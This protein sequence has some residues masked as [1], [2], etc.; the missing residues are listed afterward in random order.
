MAIG[1]DPAVPPIEGTEYAIQAVDTYEMAEQLGERTV[2]IGGGTIGCELALLLDSYGKKTTVLE[3][4]D[5]LHRQNS[6]FYDIALDQQ[7]AI[8][9]GIETITEEKVTKILENRVD[10]YRNGMLYSIPCDSVILASGLK[11]K[12][13]EA[14]SFFENEGVS[15]HMIGDCVKIGKIKD[16][17]ESA[18]FVAANI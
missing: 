16:A 17:T 8:R 5:R 14:F 11:S 10:Y 9:S 1:S 15:V 12:T 4:T 3:M 2:I 7:L 18:Y 6:L 13:D